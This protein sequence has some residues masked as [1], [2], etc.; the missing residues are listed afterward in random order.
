MPKTQTIARPPIPRPAKAGQMGAIAL[1]LMAYLAI[2]AVM[3][4]PEGY[5]ITETIPAVA[6]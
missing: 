6:E 2:L 1:F 3:F 4:A 5:F